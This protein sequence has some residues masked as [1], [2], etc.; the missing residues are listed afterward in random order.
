MGKIGQREIKLTE[1]KTILCVQEEKSYDRLERFKT[2]VIDIAVNQIN[3][4]SDITVSYTQRKSGRTV[5]HLIFSFQA[6]PLVNL[7]LLDCVQPPPKKKRFIQKLKSTPF[8]RTRNQN[9]RP[10]TQ[11]PQKQHSLIIALITF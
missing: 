9:T 6:K 10:I 11:S 7:D 4:Y 5:T 1:L 8:K 2:K 3:E